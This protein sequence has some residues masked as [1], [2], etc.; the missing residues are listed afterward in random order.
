M[1]INPSSDKQS[2]SANPLN[3]NQAASAA[4]KRVQEQNTA[5]VSNSE[6]GSE[7]RTSDDTVSLSTASLNLAKT[8]TDQN[9]N[10]PSRIEEPEQARKLA[11]QLI[12]DIRDQAKQAKSALGHVNSAQTRSLLA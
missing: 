4:T 6:N 8:S 7:S 1:N 3:T 11:G 10:R 2:V 12:S 5:S 9:T